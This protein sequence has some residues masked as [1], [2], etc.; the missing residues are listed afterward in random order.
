M[1]IYRERDIKAVEVRARGRQVRDLVSD[2]GPG[3]KVGQPMHI[4]IYI[5]IYM[6]TDIYIYI[7]TETEGERD[8]LY[9]CMCMCMCVYI[10]IYMYMYRTTQP[11][12]DRVECYPGDPCIRSSWGL[13]FWNRVREP[14]RILG[15]KGRARILRRI[16]IIIICS[17]SSNSSM[18][19]MYGTFAEIS[20][21]RSGIWGA[22]LITHATRMYIYVYTYIHAY[23]QRNI[24]YMCIHMCI[25]LCVHTCIYRARVR[26]CP[27]G[28]GCKKN[29]GGHSACQPASHNIC[30]YVYMYVYIYIYVYACNVCYD[31]LC[32]S[33]IYHRI[34]C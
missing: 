2:E 7:Y 29:I 13:D 9:I 28:S 32:Y 6:Y 24:L 20:G 17:S 25:Y 33:I 1:Y 31:V 3:S 34:L 23:I 11:V 27:P 14:G 8:V 4:Y 21:R 26:Q 16:V 5:Y 10:Y 15:N 18:V 19:R 12:T 22:K 30:I